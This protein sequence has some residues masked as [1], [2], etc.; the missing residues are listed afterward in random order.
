MRTA[1]GARGT[2]H[3]RGAAVRVEGERLI[4]S[5][6]LYVDHT[7][8]TVTIPS[9]CHH[10]QAE[11]DAAEAEGDDCWIGDCGSKATNRY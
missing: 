9:D 10:D 3:R 1:A 11:Y 2:L 6:T 7:T 5:V 8:A 4:G